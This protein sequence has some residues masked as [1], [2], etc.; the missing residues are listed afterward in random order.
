MLVRVGDRIFTGHTGGFPGHIT[1]MFVH[2]SSSTAAIG[3]MNSTSAPDPVSLTTDLAVE[4]LDNDPL[5]PEPWVPGTVVPDEL[6]GLLGTWFSEGQDFTFSV[7][8]GVLEARQAK[9]ASSKP[10]SVF[11]KLGDDLYRTESG[12][13]TGELLRVTRGP[14][15]VPVKL[16]WATYLF[17]R[18]PY[19]FGEWLD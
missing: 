16:N 4:V 2:R 14:D 13:E 19:A 15:G 6:A 11:S 10:P 9:A 12:R 18:E 17:T 8:Q 3:L 5:P 1:G 7:R